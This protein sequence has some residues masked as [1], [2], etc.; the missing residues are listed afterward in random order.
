MWGGR[1]EKHAEEHANGGVSKILYENAG[2]TKEKWGRFCDERMH[3]ELF[4]L[5]ERS[6]HSPALCKRVHICLP[7]NV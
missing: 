3:M 5:R 1:R 4:F 6:N 7:C 2:R